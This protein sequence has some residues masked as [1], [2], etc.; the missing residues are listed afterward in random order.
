MFTSI[1][2]AICIGSCSVF[3]IFLNKLNKYQIYKETENEVKA[4]NQEL[5]ETKS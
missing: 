2:E 5:L 4:Q 1:S 3:N